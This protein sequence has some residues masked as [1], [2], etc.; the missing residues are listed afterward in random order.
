MFILAYSVLILAYRYCRTN[1]DHVR[2]D[3]HR[4]EAGRRGGA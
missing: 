3:T 1:P 4:S 2:R